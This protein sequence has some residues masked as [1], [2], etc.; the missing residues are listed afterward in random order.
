MFAPKPKWDVCLLEAYFSFVRAVRNLARSTL[1]KCCGTASCALTYSCPDAPLPSRLFAAPSGHDTL[2]YGRIDGCQ[3]PPLLLG[4]ISSNE[5][6]G[7][8]FTMW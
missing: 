8:M 2:A 3:W 1:C 7:E 6:C 4:N 5:T